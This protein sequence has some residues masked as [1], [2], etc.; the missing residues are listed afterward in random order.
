M[1]LKRILVIYKK[2]ALQLYAK[3]RRDLRFLRLLRSGHQATRRFLPNHESHYEA[4]DKVRT[5][6][7]RRGLEARFVYRAQAFTDRGFDLVLTIGGD[8]TFLD[9][10]HSVTRVPVLGLNSTP[11]DSVG[12]F[13]ATTVRGLNRALDAVAEDRLGW[14]EM[15]RLHIQIGR[16]D[17]PIPVLNDILVAHANPAAMSNFTLKWG[18]RTE[19]LRS[20]GIWIAPP[21][22]TT[23]ASASAGGKVMP[24]SS[25]GYQ[26]IV[27][28]PYYSNR[29]KCR[30]ARGVL[31]SEEKLAL[32]SM[33]RNGRVFLDGSH[34]VYP[35]PVG[36][37]IVISTQAPLLRVLGFDEARRRK[38][39]S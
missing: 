5:V 34:K 12:F 13:C 26:F 9:A 1:K 22:G 15:T 3:E 39:F 11:R 10:S 23:A 35:L 20:S 27:R 25:R 30:W 7:K 33:M 31:K 36:E 8:G 32:V 4:L 37:K 21:A 17:V 18:N 6:L 16:K 38:L 28:E 2:T 14:T 24:I 29:K 19:N